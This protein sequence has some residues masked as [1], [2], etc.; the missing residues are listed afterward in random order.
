MVNGTSLA[1][2]DSYFTNNT[3]LAG[4]GIFMSRVTDTYVY[5]NHFYY[6]NVSQAGGGINAGERSAHTVQQHHC[7]VRCHA[8][9]KLQALSNVSSKSKAWGQ[10]SL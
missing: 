2:E 5:N 8:C 7:H 10:E 1:V 9:T 4:G 6:N 3:A